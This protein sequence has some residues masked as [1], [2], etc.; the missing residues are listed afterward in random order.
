MVYG[1]AGTILRI[2]LSKSKVSKTP[3]SEYTRLFVG[4]RGV[5]AK[6]MFEESDNHWSGCPSRDRNPLHDQARDYNPFSRAGAR[7]LHNAM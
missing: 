5:N 2:D 3:S 4:G 7:G 1:W 6:L